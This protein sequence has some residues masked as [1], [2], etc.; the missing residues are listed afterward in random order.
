MSPD[1][2]LLCVV[3]L[4]Y[5]VTAVSLLVYVVFVRNYCDAEKNLS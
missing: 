2:L 5:G 3:L 4:I 1:Y